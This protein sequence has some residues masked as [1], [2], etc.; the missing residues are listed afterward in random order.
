M[1]VLLK[2]LFYSDLKA[3]YKR[4]TAPGVVSEG[5]EYVCPFD[6]A[7]IIHKL[8]TTPCLQFLSV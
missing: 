7:V 1:C 5:S 6:A 4:K 8:F 3:P 2:V